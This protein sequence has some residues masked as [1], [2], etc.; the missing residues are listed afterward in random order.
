MATILSA[1]AIH[2]GKKF[3]P[4]GYSIVIDETTKDILDI[5]NHTPTNA[6]VYEGILCP[7]FVNAHCHTE[8]SHMKDAIP[9]H[10]GLVG[11]LSQINS[12]RNSTSLTEKKLAAQHTI[13]QMEQRGIVAVG[14]ICNT[15]D[16]I[17]AKQNSNIQFINFLETFGVLPSIAQERMNAITT[18]QKEF[19]TNAITSIVPHAPY[20][21]SKDLFQKINSIAAHSIL[22]IHNQECDA[23]NELF[24]H[25]S[26]D[27]VPFL[28]FVSNQ[29]YQF[30]DKAK[31]SLQYYL[32]MLNNA[33][34]I[35][36]VHNTCT[37]KE[38]VV[39]AKEQCEKRF[40]VLCPKA[41]LYIENKLPAIIPTLA[42]LNETICLGT[43]SLA[44]NDTCCIYEEMFVLQQYLGI[45][46]E[47]LLRYATFNGAEALGLPGFGKIEKGANGGIVL[48]S[49]TDENLLL[50][51]NATIQPLL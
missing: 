22:S 33:K 16:S 6:K 23:E 41:N 15:S 34:H 50:T 25:H 43:D 35:L 20:S 39:F 9:K 48:I 26:G 28:Q 7:G 19:S 2:D 44:S 32:P 18:L 45:N 8:L 37:Q 4:K 10:T 3:L 11:F 14:D 30:P 29:Q 21:V 5:L 40:W 47:D 46:T 51:A 38:D 17:D 24:S 36:F 13:A 42:A 49:N 12:N 31:S 1:T 27:F